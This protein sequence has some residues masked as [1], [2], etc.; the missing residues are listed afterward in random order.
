MA[1]AC[2]YIVTGTGILSAQLGSITTIDSDK[3]CLAE[4]T[5][6]TAAGSAPTIA[7]SGQ[8]VED[9]ATGACKCNA[10]SVSISKLHHAQDFGAFTLTTGFG[11]HLTQCT[12]TA[13]ANVS[14]AD[15]DGVPLAHDVVDGRVTVT[16]TV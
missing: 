16:G 15:K 14:T 4:I 8:Q 11:A 12:Y 10:L 5:I 13:T 6:T 2:D 1:P 3:F 7:A 9:T